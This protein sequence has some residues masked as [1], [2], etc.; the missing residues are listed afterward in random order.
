MV[1]FSNRLIPVSNCLEQD[2]HKHLNW[3]MYDKVNI[4]AILEKFPS[5]WEELYWGP[6]LQSHNQANFASVNFLH[7]RIPENLRSHPIELTSLVQD[8]P[9]AIYQGCQGF[10][11]SALGP[12][13]VKFRGLVWVPVLSPR[14]WPKLKAPSRNQFIRNS[15]RRK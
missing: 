8:S 5:M 1:K 7:G 15:D 10:R 4:L 6:L 13:W 2:I 11:D 9:V 14:L 12:N 3:A